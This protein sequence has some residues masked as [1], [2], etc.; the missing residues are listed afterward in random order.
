M[1]DMGTDDLMF[2]G[3]Q[4]DSTPLDG[5]IPD[6]EVPDQAVVDQTRPDMVQP[7]DLPLLD[8][9]T[10]QGTTCSNKGIH[11][12]SSVPPGICAKIKLQVRAKAPFAWVLARVSAASSPGSVKWMNK[13]TVT[14]CGAD[15]CWAFS[16]VQVP[17][18]AGPYTF[19]FMKDATGDDPKKGKEVGACSP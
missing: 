8:K 14:N 1:G 4:A 18:A 5:P 11:F 15:T 19:H 6:A 9:P 10:G 12:V 17:C 2:D 3:P 13:P 7:K 16:N